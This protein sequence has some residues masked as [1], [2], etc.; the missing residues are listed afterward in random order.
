LLVIGVRAATPSS[1]DLA[2]SGRRHDDD[3]PGAVRGSSSADLFDA[4]FHALHDGEQVAVGFGGPL[5]TR[6]DEDQ[7]NLEGTGQEDRAI[8][9]LDEAEA[10]APGLA[11]L[12]R[13]LG[14][15]GKWRP[16][17][18]VS[19]SLPRWRAT[20]SILVWELLPSDNAAQE[21][22]P[23]ATDAAEP[24]STV[25]DSGVHRFYELLRTRA[26]RPTDVATEPVINLAAAVALRAG[27][28]VDAR[29]LSEPVLAIVATATSGE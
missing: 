19:T 29:Q 28:P 18:A 20:T 15:L 7:R 26:D 11:G 1:D 24:D 4:V 5:T 2:W 16:W 23:L 3:N 10:A 17:T 27:L 9:L 8:A 22:D 12:D 13:L 6:V 14:E 21:T 25:A